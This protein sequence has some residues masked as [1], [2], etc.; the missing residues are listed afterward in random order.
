MEKLKTK[1]HMSIPNTHC[2]SIKQLPSLPSL[3]SGNPHPGLHCRM[4]QFKVKQKAAGHAG[5][6][7]RHNQALYVTDIAWTQPF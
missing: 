2:S 7:I 5:Q 4:I 6:N 1:K 3:L